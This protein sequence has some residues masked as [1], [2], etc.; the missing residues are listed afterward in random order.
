MQRSWLAFAA[1]AATTVVLALPGCSTDANNVTACRQLEDARCTRAQ[2]CGID[3]MY[4]LHNGT[5]AAD[6]IEACQLFY[7]DACLHGL[8]TSVVVTAPEMDRCLRAIVGGEGGAGEANCNA[9][10]NPQTIPACAW[11]IPPDA[12]V[13]AGVDAG[14]TATPDATVTVTPTADAGGDGDANPLGPCYQSCNDN[15]AGD[16]NCISSCE[17]NCQGS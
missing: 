17:T 4:P 8:V 2:K 12:G 16:P 14:T 15:C 3:L 10:I 13:D 7:Y 5:S 11:L 9:V 1:A 6:D